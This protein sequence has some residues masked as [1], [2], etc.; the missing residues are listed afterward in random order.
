MKKHSME[1]LIRGTGVAIITPFTTSGRIDF[2]S[3]D[4]LVEDVIVNKVDFIVA[5]G[6]T[7]EAVT[8]TTKEKEE[9][10]TFIKK[11]AG[12]RVPIVLGI[13]GNNTRSVVEAIK[14]TDFDGIS[15][16]LSVAPYYNKPNQSGMYGHFSEIAN[17]CPV[18]IILYNVPGRT[19]SNIDAQT[20]IS[21]AGDHW[22]IVAI[23]E[24]SGNISQAM[25]II[26][27][28]PEGFAVLSGDDALTYPLMALGADG[29][30]SV[31][32]NAY[33][34]A[35]SSM[36]RLI[37]K[38]EYDDAL[39]IHYLLLDFINLLF[40]DGNPAGI[41]AALS[42]TGMCKNVLRL[43][44]VKVNRNVYKQLKQFIGNYEYPV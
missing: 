12:G 14:R 4:L 40:T 32:A 10:V 35:F 2:R 1:G 31:V 22:N 36:V 9:V 5:L 30:I 26:R 38:K 33:P 39:A 21:L 20:I 16:I 44:M 24:A 27:K 6:T 8:L 11:S 29:V 18:D 37:Q 7:G 43:P 3:L 23:K 13:G 28:R 41:K 19:S 25:D 42:I 17:A 15:A 34:A